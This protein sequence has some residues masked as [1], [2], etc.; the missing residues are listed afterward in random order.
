MSQR[1]VP[2]YAF[3][4][5][6]P[7]HQILT[8]MPYECARSTGRLH[9]CA[10]TRYRICTRQENLRRDQPV[11]PLFLSRDMF[12]QKTRGKTRSRRRDYI[13]RAWI[14]PWHIITWI[15][16]KT[17][18]QGVK[19]SGLSQNCR[20]KSLRTYFTIE[21][22]K[23]CVSIYIRQTTIFLNFTNLLSDDD[24][25]KRDFFTSKQLLDTLLTCSLSSP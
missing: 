9:V 17:R 15:P 20:T 16:W 19:I 23:K 10:S 11:F 7:T 6:R 25:S 3:F 24:I 5:F 4:V 22:M 13:N 14:R 12:W 2:S 8:Q 18:V 1:C 21:W